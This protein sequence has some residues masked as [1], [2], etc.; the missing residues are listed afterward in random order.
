MVLGGLAASPP[1]SLSQSAVPG[2]HVRST[3]PLYE[4]SVQDSAEGSEPAGGSGSVWYEERPASAPRGRLARELPFPLTFVVESP[5]E[6]IA[7]CVE[8]G[9]VLDEVPCP[10]IPRSW[11]ARQSHK[12][13]G[14]GGQEPS[15][16]APSV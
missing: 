1:R 3:E 12:H 4:H 2:T 14:F 15:V 6:V 8:A 16:C 9:G 13:F 7:P 5:I 10:G 11:E